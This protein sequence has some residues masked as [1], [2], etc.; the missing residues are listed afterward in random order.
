MT[1]V[2]CN[3]SDRATDEGCSYGSGQLQGGGWVGG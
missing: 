2:A 3:A 1:I